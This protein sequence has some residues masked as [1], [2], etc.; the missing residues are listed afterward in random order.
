MCYI[1]LFFE[2]NSS[3]LWEDLI[4]FITSL[5]LFMT[6]QKAE[7]RMKKVCADTSMNS[8]VLT[9][10][11]FWERPF[12]KIHPKSTTR[13]FKW[14]CNSILIALEM[15][16]LCILIASGNDSHICRTS[17]FNFSGNSSTYEYD[18]ERCE[19]FVDRFAIMSFMFR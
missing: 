5:R 16:D 12:R 6:G 13:L 7:D 8:F 3:P 1:L 14:L 4:L 2:K 18:Q 11:R 15:I 19:W 9:K 17:L 10:F